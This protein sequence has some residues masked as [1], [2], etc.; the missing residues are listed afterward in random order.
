MLPV[1]GYILK[2]TAFCNLNC[3]YCYMFNLGD[4]SYLGRPKVMPLELVAVTAQRIT[5]YAV[6]HQQRRLLI[7]IH[8]GEPLLAGRDWLRATVHQFR[9]ASDGRVDFR[10]GLQTNGVLLDTDW[11]DLFR[12][13]GVS[14]S[15]SMDGPKHV[16]DRA[17]VNHAGRGSYDEVV[18]GL[19]LLL[20]AP[21]VDQLFGGIL[22]VIDPTEDGLA[23]YR[24]FRELGVSRVDFLLPLEYHW[25]N[26]PP[27]YEDPTATPFADY[28]IPIF[29]DWWAED[30]PRV[31]VRLFFDVIKLL[32]GG[33]Q[34]IDSLGGDPVDLAVIETDGSLEPLDA[35]RACGDGFTQLG[36]NVR[37]DPIAALH[38]QPLFRAAMAGQEGLCATCQACSLRT[39]CGGGYLPNRYSR[40]RGFDNPSIYCRDLYKLISHIIDTV[41]ERTQPAAAPTA[42]GR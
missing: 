16:H 26:P 3:S 12:E 36:L 41:W 4:R 24:H 6:A 21:D 2:A 28:L 9:A 20:D 14:V 22:C 39:V 19:R 25:D 30:N 5:E 13:L 17:R 38:D 37:R 8:G 42:V 34:H 35:L 33:R 1:G 15:L 23:I 31:L 40:T 29:D 10:F 27:G 11:L 32:F 7:T 18:R